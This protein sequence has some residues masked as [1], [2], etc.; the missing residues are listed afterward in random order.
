MKLITTP[1]AAQPL[2]HYSQAVTHNGL[3][4]T[5][6]QLGIDPQNPSAEPGDI[7][8]Q[9]RLALQNLEAILV[10]AGS[11]LTQVIKVVVYLTDVAF[12]GD[13][14]TVYASVFKD[15]RPAR[16]AVPVKALPKGYL[17]EIEAIASL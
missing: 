14:N 2:G 11:S 16:S 5:S 6:G 9:T 12:W 15:H 1:N 10:A 3:I 4:Y 13:M 17:V 8:T 7:H